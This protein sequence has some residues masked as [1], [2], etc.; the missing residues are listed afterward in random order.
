MDHVYKNNIVTPEQTAGEK[1][2]WGTVK[3]LLINKSI[4]KEVRSMPRNLV[5]FWLDY[6]K[7][8]NSILHSWLLPA[9]KLAKLS[10]YL[11]LAIKNL[12]ES[13]YAKLNLNGKDDSIVSNVIKIIT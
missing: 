5:T 8:F 10:N 4:L 11:L 3:Q 1:R 6:R 7:A 2:V 9:L 13:W 12:T